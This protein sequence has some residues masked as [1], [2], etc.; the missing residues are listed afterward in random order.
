MKATNF[1]VKIERKIHQLDATDQAVGRLAGQVAVL[2]RGKHK[3][4]FL[5]QIDNGD[6]VCVANVDKM[7]FTGKKLEQKKIYHHSGYPGGLKTKKLSE[8]YQKNPQQ[9]LQNAVS[10]MLPKNK[11]RDKMLKRLSFKQ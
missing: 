9:V 1:K 5:P 4:D 10:R 2:L 8:V 7:K 6:L 3:V 11:F